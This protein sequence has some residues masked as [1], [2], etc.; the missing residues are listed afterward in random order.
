MLSLSLS[1]GWFIMLTPGVIYLQVRKRWWCWC[2]INNV[3]GY[4]LDLYFMVLEVSMRANFEQSSQQRILLTSTNAPAGALRFG[5]S[6]H[7]VNCDAHGFVALMS[8]ARVEGLLS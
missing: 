1:S 5:T 6:R 8:V 4:V 3:C 2:P 7:A